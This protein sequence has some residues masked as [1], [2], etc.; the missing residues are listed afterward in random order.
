MKLKIYE[1]PDPFVLYP[2]DLEYLSPNHF[3]LGSNTY[4]ADFPITNLRQYQHI[5]NMKNHFWYRWSSEYLNQLQQRTK[6]WLKQNNNIEIDVMVLIVEDNITSSLWR[7]G[8]ILEIH[9]GKDGEIRV[10]S[11]HTKA[12]LLKRS[13]VKICLFPKLWLLLH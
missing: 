10:V 1:I 12:G 9:R 6:W 7:I 4:I 2:N 11:V 13:I 5:I 8:R 3:L